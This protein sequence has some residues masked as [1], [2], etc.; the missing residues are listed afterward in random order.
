MVRTH[1]S[2]HL[3]TGPSKKISSFSA[4]TKRSFPDSSSRR[5]GGAWAGPLEWSIGCMAA[6]R[7]LL[8]VL[9]ENRQQMRTTSSPG[10][11]LW[12]CSFVMTRRCFRRVASERTVGAITWRSSSSESRLRSSK[13]K[14][15]VRVGR[16]QKDNEETHWGLG[17]DFWT[18]G[19]WTWTCVRLLGLGVTLETGLGLLSN[20][21]RQ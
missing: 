20:N 9:I 13:Q 12:R 10:P 4:S 15:A 5:S 11:V 1:G 18:D 16:T 21:L 6:T 2:T 3:R 17:L 7:S 14:S 19:A 8:N